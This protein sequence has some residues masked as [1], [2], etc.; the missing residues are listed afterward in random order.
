VHSVS[1]SATASATNSMAARE[2]LRSGHSTIS[3]GIDEKPSRPHSSSSLRAAWLSMSKCT[4][5]MSSG[6]RLRA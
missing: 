4:A 5:R 2:S 6:E 3:S 1:P